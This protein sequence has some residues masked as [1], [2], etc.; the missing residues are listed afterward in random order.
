MRHQ[1]ALLLLT[2]GKEDEVGSSSRTHLMKN[3]FQIFWHCWRSAITSR[4]SL[5]K[6]LPFSSMLC[7]GRNSS[8]RMLG[9]PEMT[10]AP[11]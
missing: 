11:F 9:D 4:R 1:C 8:F 6:A 10:W 7:Q 2:L 5:D 3:L